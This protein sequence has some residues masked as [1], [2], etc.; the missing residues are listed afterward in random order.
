LSS[1]TTVGLDLTPAG[2]FRFA[3]GLEASGSHLVA[4]RD[5]F[6]RPVMRRVVV[7]KAIRRKQRTPTNRIMGRVTAS[8]IADASEAS[9][10]CRRHQGPHRNRG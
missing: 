6:T 8:Q 4:E 2:V 7:A 3:A 9:F 5:Q 10:F 1:V